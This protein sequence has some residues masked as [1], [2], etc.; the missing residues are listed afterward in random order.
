MIKNIEGLD[1]LVTLQELDLYDNQ[2]EKLENLELL[3]NL[4]YKNTLFFKWTCFS[5]KYFSTSFIFSR[6]L[7]LSFNAIKVVENLAALVQLQKLFLVQNRVSKIE[8]LTALS[9]LTMLELGANNIR[10]KHAIFQIYHIVCH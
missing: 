9:S 8:N 6:I 2:I 5:L 7:D 1:T 4:K 10:V 3:V